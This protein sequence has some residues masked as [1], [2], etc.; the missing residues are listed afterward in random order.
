MV[1]GNGHIEE[2]CCFQIVFGKPVDEQYYW[3]HDCHEL[4]HEPCKTAKTLVETCRRFLLRNGAGHGAEIGANAS[5]DDN[6]G[7]CSALNAGAHEACVLELNWGV[8]SVWVGIVELLYGERLP[9]QRPLAHE[10]ILRGQNPHVA[11]DHV[12]CR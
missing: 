7:R 12:S 3:Q 4:D 6:R 2:E 9:G 1:D 11:R 8:C 5:H 10:Q